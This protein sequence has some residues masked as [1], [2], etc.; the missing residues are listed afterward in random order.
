[1]AVEFGKSLLPFL[2]VTG[3]GVEK[4][5]FAPKVQPSAQFKIKAYAAIPYEKSPQLTDT[6]PTK[7]K[8][9]MPLLAGYVTP[10]KVW[11]A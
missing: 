9:G 5:A 1:M 4:G 11:T 8:S 2:G 3:K 7:D 10:E 6:V